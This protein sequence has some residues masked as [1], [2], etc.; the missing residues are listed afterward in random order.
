MQI[1]LLVSIWWE[2]L[3]INWLTHFLLLF[4]AFSSWPGFCSSKIYLLSIRF[5]KI[6]RYRFVRVYFRFIVIKVDV[7]YTVTNLWIFSS[8]TAFDFI[9]LS[10][11]LTHF[12][13]V[14]HFYTPWKPQRTYGFLTFSGG[15]EIWHGLKW[16][17]WI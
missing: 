5:K 8:P 12:S 13:P 14:S 10:L 4:Q 1:N 3:V 17:N 6:E 9:Q 16:V 11:R 2:T 7:D 15:V